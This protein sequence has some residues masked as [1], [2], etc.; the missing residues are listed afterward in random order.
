MDTKKAYNMLKEAGLKV[1]RLYG[2]GRTISIFETCADVQNVVRRRTNMYQKVVLDF[3]RSRRWNLRQ[4]ELLSDEEKFQIAPLIKV[5]KFQGSVP[6]RIMD[7]TRVKDTGFSA[8]YR[9]WVPNPFGIPEY[10]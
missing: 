9:Y 3:G 4:I 8:Q 5:L 2:Y 6:G 1:V 10:R 7:M